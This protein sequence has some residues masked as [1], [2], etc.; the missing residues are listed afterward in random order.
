MLSVICYLLST[1]DAIIFLTTLLG[2][3][4]Y[5]MSRTMHILINLNEP[6]D[7]VLKWCESIW[8]KEVKICNF[9]SKYLPCRHV[10]PQIDHV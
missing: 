8:R 10:M 4:H 5:W 7:N 1:E 9:F 6:T 2:V 3:A